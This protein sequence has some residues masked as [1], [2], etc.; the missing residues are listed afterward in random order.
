M[1]SYKEKATP[2]AKSKSAT[3]INSQRKET[4]P[5]L[6]SL[7]VTLRMTGVR[8]TL[9]KNS[10]NIG[11][12]WSKKF[13]RKVPI[14]LHSKNFVTALK[15]G[16]PQL[17]HQWGNR[18]PVGSADER[19]WVMA[20]F[21]SGKGSVPDLDGCMVGLGDLLQRAGIITNDRWIASWDGSR[22]IEWRTHNAEPGTDL[23]ISCF[24][25]DGLDY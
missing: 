6:T 16:M 21:Y 25:G 18:S 7:P 12:V 24:T 23:T 20:H 4:S 10:R 2:K 5:G 15:I 13:K 17:K 9:A 11:L 8:P 1:T 3:A 19:L 22:I 14:S